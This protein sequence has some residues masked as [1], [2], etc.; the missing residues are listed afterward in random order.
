[1]KNDDRRGRQVDLSDYAR[2]SNTH[3]YYTRARFCLL[4]VS[5]N[6]LFGV[7]ERRA[8]RNDRSISVSLNSGRITDSGGQRGNWNRLLNRV[9]RVKNITLGVI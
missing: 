6:I 5:A 9:S 1:M 2:E 7:A 3:T 4:V 8:R